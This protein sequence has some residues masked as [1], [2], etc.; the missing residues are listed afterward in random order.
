M[1]LA[2]APWYDSAVWGFIAVPIAMFA[3]FAAV[4]IGLKTIPRRI[5]LTVTFTRFPLLNRAA[6]VGESSKFNLTYDGIALKNPQVCAATLINRGNSDIPREAFDGAQPIILDFGGEVRDLLAPA[7]DD[8]SITPEC[9]IS[10]TTVEVLPQLLRS[11]QPYVV[12]ALVEEP[13]ER[14]H[15]QDHLVN[16]YVTRISAYDDAR[17][18]GTTPDVLL[19]TGPIVITGAALAVTF[20]AVGLHGVWPAVIAT[21]ISSVLLALTVG[22]FRDVS[23]WRSL[24]HDS[25]ADQTEHDE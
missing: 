15:I 22:Q 10:G 9:R 18:P 17:R 2:S 23:P 5:P 24:E 20:A 14:F 16:V 8:G 21:T 13:G 19:M 7:E 11:K 6:V 12:R 4:W 1:T 25:A 3:I